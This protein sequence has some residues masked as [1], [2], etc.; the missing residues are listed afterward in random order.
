MDSGEQH[1]TSENGGRGSDVQEQEREGREGRQQVPT[2]PTLL[3]VRRRKRRAHRRVAPTDQRALRGRI[4]GLSEILLQE[5]HVKWKTQVKS[6]AIQDMFKLLSKAFPAGDWSWLDILK[7]L[8]ARQRNR[9]CKYRAVAKRGDPMPVDCPIK[10][11]QVFQREV[12]RH[13]QN[14]NWNLSQRNALAARRGKNRWGSGGIDS[15]QK[16]FKEKFDVEAPFEYVQ[17]I[18]EVGV[19]QFWIEFDR[20]GLADLH[21]RVEED[22]DEEESSSST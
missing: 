5:C 16:K 2:L 1:A 11:W 7:T 20:L 17:R 13:R 12:Q 6:R 18:R 4:R 14:P 22:S 9:R 21:S 3:Q 19:E 8:D 15:F 10:S